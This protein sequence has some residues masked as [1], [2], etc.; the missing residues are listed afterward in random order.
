MGLGRV[1]GGVSVL[2]VLA[3][4]L[5]YLGIHLCFSIMKV[6]FCLSSL[7]FSSLVSG[8]LPLKVE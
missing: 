1:E 2:V 3:N 4:G 8:T 5:S 6:I 7:S